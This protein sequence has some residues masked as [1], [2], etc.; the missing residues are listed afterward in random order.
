[1]NFKKNVVREFTIK[2]S[3]DADTVKVFM[4]DQLY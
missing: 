4:N 2:L 1:V 3:L